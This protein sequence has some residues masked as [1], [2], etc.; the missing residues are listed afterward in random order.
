MNMK[1]SK[2][3]IEEASKELPIGAGG[4]RKTRSAR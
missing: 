1:V 2:K 3:A 4:A